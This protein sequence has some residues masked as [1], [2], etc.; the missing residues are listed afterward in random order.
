MES[1]QRRKLSRGLPAIAAIAVLGLVTACVSVSVNSSD[2]P[3]PVTEPGAYT[4]AFVERAIERY[5]DEGL[6]KTVAYYNTAES[7]DGDWYVFI[8]NEDDVFLSHPTIPANV[9]KDLTSD[10]FVGADGFHFGKALVAATEDGDWVSYHY[11]NPN[12]NAE[13]QKH[14]WVVERDGL[15]FGSGWYQRSP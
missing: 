3:S 13:E 8:L 14:S 5:D 10:E 12:S 11:L 7:V 4:K 15:I 9:G 6:E 1:R 2:S